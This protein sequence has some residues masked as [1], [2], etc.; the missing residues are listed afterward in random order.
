MQ[1]RTVVEGDPVPVNCDN[2]KIVFLQI[3]L[4]VYGSLPSFAFL[5]EAVTWEPVSSCSRGSPFNARQNHILKSQKTDYSV[6]CKMLDKECQI[7]FA[8]TMCKSYWQGSGSCLIPPLSTSTKNLPLPRGRQIYT[9]SPSRT[10][11]SSRNLCQPISWILVLLSPWSIITSYS[12]S[13]LVAKIGL[14]T[15]LFSLVATDC[16]CSIY[17]PR[18]CLLQHGTN[19]KWWDQ[20]HGSLSRL[21]SS[22]ATSWWLGLTD[23]NQ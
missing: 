20:K 22:R 15:G 10:A 14:P 11:Y 5:K 19:R 18:T 1:I 16:I 21:K 17:A 6:K 9:M 3:K 8:N 2:H 13:S 7:S 4:S 12:S 23:S